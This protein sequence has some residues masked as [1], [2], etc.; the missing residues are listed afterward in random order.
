MEKLNTIGI[1]FYKFVANQNLI[2]TVYKNVLQLDYI[3]DPNPSLG[4]VHENYFNEELFDWFDTCINQVATQ[5]Y[6]ESLS[7]PII[8]CWVNKYTALTRLHKHNH[9]NSIICGLYY[10]TDHDSGNTIFEYPNPWTYFSGDTKFNLSIDKSHNNTLE[11]QIKPTAGKLIL[12]P[13]N[14]LHY[15]KTFKDVQNNRYTIAFNTFPKGQVSDHNTMR[16][17]LNTIS[18]RDLYKKGKQ[19]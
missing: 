10:V 3:T 2:D 13:G 19:D 17:N 11:G 18:I 1:P 4:S 16:L 7:F 8:D 6:V 12:F 9:Y 15:V 14:I 5:H